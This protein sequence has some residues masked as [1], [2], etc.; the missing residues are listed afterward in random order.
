[1]RRWHDWWFRLRAA[2]FPSRQERELDQELEFH[3]A[4]QAEQLRREGV[5]PEEA[6]REAVRRF[7]GLGREREVVRDAWGIGWIRDLAADLRHTVRQA[8]RRP[9]YTVL[10]VATLAL[11]IG[12]TVA[13]FSVVRGL[14]I[15][16]LPVAQEERLRVFWSDYNWRGVEFD[17]VRERI[18]AFEG[19]AAFSNELVTLRGDQGST[20]VLTVVGS[21]ELFDVLGRAP[22][23]G[24]TFRA[25][26][27]RPGADPG[28]VISYG[29]WQQELGADSAIIGRR[30]VFGGVPTTVIGV[31]PR[32][33]YFPS[34]EYRAWK[35]LD[36]DPASGQYQGNGWLVL[37]GRTKADVSEARVADDIAAIAQSL[38]ERFTYPAAWDKTKNASSRPLRVYLLGDVKPMLLLLLG[39]V[40]MVL[41]MACANTAALVLART[42]DRTNEMTLRVALGAGRHRLARQVI[43]ESVALSV[44]AAGLGAAIAAAVFQTL[45]AS[46]PLGSFGAVVSLDWLTFAAA[47]GLAVLVG[48]LV[49]ILPVRTLLDGRLAGLGSERS[50]PGLR[51]GPGRAHAVLV[52]VEVALAVML[53]AGAA[54]FVRSVGRLAAIDPG[55]DSAGV[56]TVD[57]VTP[58]TDLDPPSRRQFFRDAIAAAARVPG[59]TRAAL[60]SRLPIRDGGWQ[61]TVT[62]DGRPDLAGPNE[63][64]SLYRP[65]TPGYFATMGVRIVQGRGFDD[66]DRTGGMPVGIV[67]E[68]FARRA[69]PG[70]DPIGRRLRA[71][72]T[73][74][75]AWVTVVGVAE[76]TRMV[77][78]VGDNPL[79]L[80][81]PWE[82]LR[83]APEGGVLIVKGGRDSEVAIGAVERVIRALDARVAMARPGSLDSV[84]GQSLAEPL[85]LRFFLSLFAG[86]ALMLGA[87]GVY[88]VVSYGV[89][90]RRAEFGVRLALGAA[91]SRVMSEVVGRGMKP[92]VA[93]VVVGLALAVGLSRLVAG[94][95]YGISAVDLA[96]YFAAGGALLLAGLIAAVSPGWRAGRVDPV[97]SLRSD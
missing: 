39:A 4:M 20:P 97:E 77:R 19:L 73:G 58:S 27:D 9:G 38:G 15:R 75:T 57:L 74:D 16:P 53:A 60:I 50:T 70:L 21:A 91:P 81:V 7:G 41:V 8:W 5:S 89:A 94:F 23:M 49:S 61:G 42:T 48:L 46:L 68:S 67:S 79:T 92:V 93:G 14:L 83:F 51:R 80:Y 3:L 78:L 24:R 64:N 32:G 26:E 6:R 11:G 85:R 44:A 43:T 54:L 22:L 45:V 66:T 40:G 12:A 37:I 82:Q 62:I 52:G 71:G 25:G 47:I 55:F 63:P 28:I 59:V 88:G 2:L 95:L 17:F 56:M 36:L 69:W 10:G 31:M 13:I 65:V 30:I 18:Q 87:V 90:R 84:V 86:V 96:S 1:M 33:F 35:P 29:L 34:P 72:M 76:E